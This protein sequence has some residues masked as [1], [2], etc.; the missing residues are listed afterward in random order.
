M[1]DKFPQTNLEIIILYKKTKFLTQTNLTDLKKKN[2]SVIFIHCNKIN[3]SSTVATLLL[4]RFSFASWDDGKKKKWET[5]QVRLFQTVDTR[6]IRQI[7]K[8]R[9]WHFGH[10]E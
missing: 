10:L 1:L 2:S 4:V 7:G 9:V 8:K 3:N 5:R 6:S